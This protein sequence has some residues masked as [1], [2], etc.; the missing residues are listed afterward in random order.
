M[1]RV[2][3]KG[4]R[5]DTWIIRGLGVPT[6]P[7]VKNQLTT[8]HWPPIYTV[9]PHLWFCIQGF[10]QTHIVEST[11][12]TTKKICISGYTQSSNLY[13]SGVSCSQSIKKQKS[14]YIIQIYNQIS[15][16]P[17]WALA[18]SNKCLLNNQEYIR[19]FLISLQKSLSINYD[20]L[21]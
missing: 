13:C 14:P 17:V 9:S 20:K 1:G 8:Y 15:S 5:V 12:F 10:N 19:I 21:L 3:E 11:V 6:I 18:Q 16:G 7:V 2:L 4:C